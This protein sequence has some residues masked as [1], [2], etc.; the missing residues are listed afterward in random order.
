MLVALACLSSNFGSSRPTVE[1][2]RL[3]LSIVCPGRVKSLKD[4]SNSPRHSFN[5][6]AEFGDSSC[7]R[8]MPQRATSFPGQTEAAILAGVLAA[9][10]AAL[11]H[12]GLDL[13]VWGA[14]RL[15]D[16][17]TLRHL[18]ANGGGFSWTSPMDGGRQALGG[19]H[20]PLGGFKERP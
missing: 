6:Q 10:E 4:D 5:H 8:I 16:Q 7:P 3:S 1:A 18:L 2:S 19:Q 14:A 20:L 12:Q 13:L 9:A 11:P 17:T 15:G